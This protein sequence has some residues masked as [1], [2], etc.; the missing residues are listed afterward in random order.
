MMLL[1][2]GGFLILI[3]ALLAVDLLGH[4]GGREPRL[5]ESAAWTAFWIALALL[6]YAGV[7]I[8][9]GP[10]SG[11][12]FL[13]GYLLEKSLSVDNMFVFALIF[14]YFGVPARHQ[15]KVLFWG[16]LGALL[17]RGLMIGAGAFL[18]DR[19]HWVL[20]VFGGF[21]VLTGVR[22]A[23]RP[24]HDLDPESTLVIRLARRF[25]P[26]TGAYHG[27]RFVV[28]VG[29]GRGRLHATPLLLVLLMVEATDVVFAVDSIPAVF[30]VTT[31]PFIVFTSNVFAI[32]GL[33]SL[34]FLLA[35]VMDRFH[36]LRIGL[37][38][39]LVFIGAKMLLEDAYHVSI[40]QSLT[41]IATTIAASV[42]ASLFWPP[43]DR[44]SHPQPRVSGQDAPPPALS[45]TPG[46]TP[47]EIL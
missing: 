22:M 13:T 8:V 19:F 14:A 38:L 42:A 6:F 1:T 3:L 12:E 30:A 41:V 7:H 10:S 26:V 4:R 9:M 16:I 15:H 21:L 47:D 43:A 46:P 44:P 17:L 11:L 2:W 32:L 25:V 18:I 24:A 27:G 37:S 5:R 36:Y 31:D 39:V 40:V 33:R 45:S 28:R 34:Y 20:Y 23:F 35:G 29:D